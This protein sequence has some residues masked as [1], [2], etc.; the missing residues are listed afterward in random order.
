VTGG[1]AHGGRFFHYRMGGAF[2]IHVEAGGRSFYHNGS[3]DLVDAE[4]QSLHADVLLVGLAGRQGTRDYLRRLVRLLSPSA[5]VPTHHDQFF[6]PLEAGVR[7]LPGVALDGFLGESLDIAPSS[8]VFTP[9]YDDEL[10]VPIDG[11]PRDAAF[12]PWG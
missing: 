9:T 5:I 1:L 8:R 3:A 7:L 2:G 11:D 12:V 6:A 4:L 10:R